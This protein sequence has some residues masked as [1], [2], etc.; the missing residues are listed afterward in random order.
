MIESLRLINF[1]GH[2]ETEISL[3]QMTALVGPNSSGKTSILQALHFLSLL[4]TMTP[5]Q[6]FRK[7]ADSNEYV[8]N[9]EKFI[10]LFLK[11]S[12]AGRPW[13]LSLQ[14]KYV[15]N[16]WTHNSSWVWKDKSE[17][18]EGG[19]RVNLTLP[20]PNHA[21]LFNA[22]YLKLNSQNLATPSYTQEEI[23]KVE[24]DG[25]GLASTISYLKTYEDERFEALMDLVRQVIPQVKRIRVRK[26]QVQLSQKR[27]FSVDNT[28]IPFE[29]SREIWGDE[30]V[31]DM[32]GAKEVP[33]HAVSEGTILAV[34][35]LTVLVSPS[36]PNVVLLDDVEQA[37]HPKAQ[38]E[39]VEVLKSLLKKNENLQIVMTTH[40]PYVVDQLDPSDVC[41]LATDSQGIVHAQPLAKHPN[42]KQAL[43]ILT[44]G[45]F[46]SAEGENWVLPAESNND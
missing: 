29:D 37:L 6:I 45:E 1:K 27:V 12:K 42:A 3:N 39:L 13:N 16:S 24:H 2:Q 25:W 46:L 5:N 17:E 34:G 33:A 8:R 19:F 14:S 11:G 30:L 36:C 28:N 32:I 38:R 41:V 7:E 40:S 18:S 20:D 26:A 21:L 35:L 44:T 31:F 23:P 43:N 15:E 9:G 22:V 4:G 10:N